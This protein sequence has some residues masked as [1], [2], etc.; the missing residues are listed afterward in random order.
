MSSRS[1]LIVGCS[2]GLAACTGLSPA[3]TAPVTPVSATAPDRVWF[4]GS[5]NI[6]NFSCRATQVA[7]S[8]EAA[9][10]EFD[11]TRADGVPAVRTGALA[12]PVRSLD[13]GIQKM[14]HD[15]LTTLGGTVNPTISF[16]LWNYVMLDRNDSRSVRMNG[17]L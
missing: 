3:P 6:R 16:R 1:L 2:A 11:R 10:E 4:T 12:I 5:S 9:I 17:L 14:N 13:C 8:A 7:V 15:L